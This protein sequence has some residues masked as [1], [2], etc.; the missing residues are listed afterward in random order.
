VIEPLSDIK[1]LLEAI[2]SSALKRSKVCKIF[3]MCGVKYF[4][5]GTY[6]AL[7]IGYILDI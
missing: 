1:I 3:G 6:R 4:K 7:G 5:L 2:V